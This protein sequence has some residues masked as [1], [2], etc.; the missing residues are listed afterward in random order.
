M[1]HKRT[2]PYFERL[3]A[4]VGS[5]VKAQRLRQGLT[6]G[7]VARSAAVSDKFVSRVET[8]GENLSLHS[9]GAL[10]QALRLKAGDLLPH[11][12]GQVD[13]SKL[14]I[15]AKALIDVIDG[16]PRRRKSLKLVIKLLEAF[17][18]EE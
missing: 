11:G 2:G 7:Q 1:P 12:D 10:A 13:G 8:A 18:S 15:E 5:Q 16:H 9:I 4:Y 3:E 6:Q 17:A 14:A